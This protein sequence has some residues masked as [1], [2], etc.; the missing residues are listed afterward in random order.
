MKDQ[1][2]TDERRVTANGFPLAAPQIEKFSAAELSNL[3]NELFR[4]QLDSWQ[5]ADLAANFLAG[6]GYGANAENL[7]EA[8]GGL[9]ISRCSL[10][11]LQ[12]ALEGVAYI[13]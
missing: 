9:E 12:S 10:D 5:A 1:V 8:I 2:R 3:R 7:R 13:Q 6:H 11:C 4:G